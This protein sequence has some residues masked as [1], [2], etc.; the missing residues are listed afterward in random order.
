MAIPV[1]CTSIRPISGTANKIYETQIPISCGG[2]TVD[3][4]A[5]TASACATR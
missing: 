3:P 1:Y 2:I 4:G 5:R